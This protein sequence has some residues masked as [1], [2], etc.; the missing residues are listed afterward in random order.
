MKK[1][2]KYPI[3]KKLNNPITEEKQKQ[4]KYKNKKVVVDGI[5]FDSKK[6]GNRYKELKLMEKSGIISDLRL[7]VKFELQPSYKFNSKTIRAINY[8][9]DFVYQINYADV[10]H[11]TMLRTKTVVEDT[12][13]YRTEVYKLKKKMFEYKYSTEIQEI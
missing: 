7:Q 6:E 11:P 12:K 9:A 5:K 13:G 8:I 2:I 3:P 10:E 1:E 4:S